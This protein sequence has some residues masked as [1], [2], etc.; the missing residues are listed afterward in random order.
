MK[1][2]CPIISPVI[3]CCNLLSFSGG[4]GRFGPWKY[5]FT[6]SNLDIYLLARPSDYFP[7]GSCTLQLLFAVRCS[8]DSRLSISLG[9]VVTP[10]GLPCE[11]HSDRSSSFN[12]CTAIRWFSGNRN[13][14]TPWSSRSPA[15]AA[16]FH[17]SLGSNGTAGEV[18]D[19]MVH[20][21]DSST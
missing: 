13:G 2:R 3:A 20:A 12:G 9:L 8:S 5:S 4:L 11:G 7:E 21:N 1:L 17:T 19:S 6:G 14:S 10:P 16:G 18:G 15:E